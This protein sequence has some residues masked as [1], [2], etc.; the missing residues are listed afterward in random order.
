[1]RILMVSAWPMHGEG[2]IATY[3]GIL[4]R[5]LALE[6]HLV[7][8]LWHEADRAAAR[9][10]DGHVRPDET[11]LD[12][13]Q[14]DERLRWNERVRRTL[15]NAL[16]D[17]GIHQYDVVHAQ[18]AI[19]S[20]A[21]SEAVA[22]GVA[23]VTTLHGSLV[24]EMELILR[25]GWDDH[26][27]A[28]YR[29]LE[30]EGAV[31]PVRTMVPAES[32]RRQ[33][34]TLSGV[35][36]ERV[37]VVPYGLDAALLEAQSLTGNPADAAE[38]GVP[39]LLSPARLSRVKNPMGLLWAARE[40]RRMGKRFELWFAG[41]GELSGDLRRA[42][43]D[44]GISDCV[45]FLGHRDDVPSLIRRCD[46]VVLNSLQEVLPFALLEAQMLGRPVVATR[47]GGVADV[48]L[49]GRT[50]LLFD[51]GDPSQIVGTLAQMLD[52]EE[53]RTQ[54]GREARRH[55]MAAFRAEQMVAQVLQVY[56]QAVREAEGGMETA[57]P[58]EIEDVGPP[59]IAAAPEDSGD[60][61]IPRR[62][63][64]QSGALNRT[65]LRRRTRR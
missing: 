57:P 37:A 17:A 25:S 60:L 7:D 30:Y 3:R 45:R 41:D 58:P 20:V 42:A 38:T 36:L 15:R 32:L 14:V 19:A 13:L 21:V 64:G 62:P 6:G 35:P 26:T 8:L 29:K 24:R 47:V 43:E 2:G 50:G 34:G 53:L 28:Y 40:L 54:M 31:Q 55:A 27:H 22:P 4:Q 10:S 12:L 51:G 63:P 56:L 23:H 49:H 39:V 16:R 44:Y 46:V 33:L 65:Y 11:M 18:D 59:R 5:G 52:S 1:M 61:A 48:I 9:H